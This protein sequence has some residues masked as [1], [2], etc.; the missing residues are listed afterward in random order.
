MEPAAICL[1]LPSLM[2]SLLSARLLPALP[3]RRSPDRSS[4]PTRCLVSGAQFEVALGKNAQQVRAISR[5]SSFQPLDNTSRVS[6]ASVMSGIMVAVS[7]PI[8]A[9]PWPAVSTAFVSQ[10]EGEPIRTHTFLPDELRSLEPIDE[11]RRSPTICR[12]R[13]SGT[14]PRRLPPKQEKGRFVAPQVSPQ[15]ITPEA[16]GRKL[17]SQF[18]KMPSFAPACANWGICPMDPAFSATYLGSILGPE[19]SHSSND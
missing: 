16:T 6:R 18:L 2:I 11:L 19:D 7:S 17:G 14:Q 5:N 4:S 10:S 3:F 9:R 12:P 8:L 13:R 15:H 1:L